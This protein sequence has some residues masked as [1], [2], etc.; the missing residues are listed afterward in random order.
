M[1]AFLPASGVDDP[2]RFAG[3]R[4]EIE[5]LTN[6]LLTT[7]SVP[8]IYGHRGLGKSSLALQLSRIAQGDVELLEELELD[9]LALPPEHQFI[10]L[11]VNCS[12]STKNLAGLLQLMINSIE[13]MRD[14]KESEAGRDRHRLIDKTT[15]RSLSLKVFSSE[16]T[17]HYDTQKRILDDADFSREER[18]VRLAE[19]MTDTFQQP[20]LFIVDE[21]DRVKGTSGVASFL[22][23]YSNE[24][25]KVAL[26]GIGTTESALLRDHASLNRQLVPVRVPLMSG[27]DLESIFDRTEDYLLEHGLEIRFSDS[28]AARAARVAAGFPWFMHLLGQTALI[29][30]HRRGARGVSESDI[31]AAL[32]S[33]PRRRLA[34][35]FNDRYMLAVKDSYAREL[36]LRLFAEWKDEDVPTS[37]IYKRATSLG[38]TGPSTYAGHLAREQ[39]GSVIARSPQQGRLYR[40]TDEMFKAYVRM[41]GSVYEGVADL[42]KGS[43]S[44]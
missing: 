27:P 13:S 28:A 22:K 20:V 44:S 4:E 2:H 3:R 33:L 1:N 38:V 42:V 39:C 10:V 31:A 15:R 41:R 18:L 35:Q 16:T 17:R 21:F 25:F 30:A 32:Q 6:A 8:L 12:D 36:V 14:Q 24:F 5:E 9:E 19:L 34:K 29:D 26:V 11:M 7:G 43:F 37:E 40:F 23:S